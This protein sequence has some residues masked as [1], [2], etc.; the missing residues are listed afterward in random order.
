MEYTSSITIYVTWP[1]KYRKRTR[2]TTGVVVLEVHSR[3]LGTAQ[4]STRYRDLADLA[5][6]AHT[7]P[8]VIDDL[9]RALAS[10]VRRRGLELPGG[11]PSPEAAGWRAGYARVTRDVPGLRER[12][13]DS[14]LATVHRFLDP[15]FDGTAAGTWDSRDLTWSG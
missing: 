12:D 3:A 6:I 2:T 11:L 8:I 9:R 15:V 13:L 10:E 14:A 1:P 4:P 5:L 7:Q